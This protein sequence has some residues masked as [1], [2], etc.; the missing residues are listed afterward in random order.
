MET[1]TEDWKRLGRYIKDRRERLR[2]TQQG[3]YAR[4]GP[5]VATI[6]NLEAGEQTSYRPRTRDQI[7]QA[8]GWAAGSVDAILAGGEPSVPSST[9]SPPTGHAEPNAPAPPPPARP[10]PE[11]PRTVEEI[12]AEISVILARMSPEERAQWERDM[13]AEDE[14]LEL[15]R[16]RRRLQWARLMRG[17]SPEVD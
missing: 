11:A 3:M 9:S 4:G 6:R 5:S 15:I 8:L 14:R 13:A 1:T 7:E 10:A 12:Q 16:Q 17:E 2:L